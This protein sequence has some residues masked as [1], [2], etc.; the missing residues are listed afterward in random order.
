ME[1]LRRRELDV[2]VEDAIETL[3]AIYEKPHNNFEKW[4]QYSKL[5]RFK[6]KE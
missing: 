3:C 2:Q 1:K 5:L 4:S 6:I